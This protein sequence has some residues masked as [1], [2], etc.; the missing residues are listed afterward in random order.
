MTDRQTDRQDG[1]QAGNQAGRQVGMLA[2]RQTKVV[3]FVSKTRLTSK[4]NE[5]QA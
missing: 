5:I 1:R 4:S 3:G 2:G